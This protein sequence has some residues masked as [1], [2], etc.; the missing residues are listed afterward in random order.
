MEQLSFVVFQWTPPKSFYHYILLITSL[1]IH[2]CVCTVLFLKCIP[3][4]ESDSS[5]RS[6][7]STWSIHVHS[8]IWVTIIPFDSCHYLQ[9]VYIEPFVLFCRPPPFPW[10]FLN[11]FMTSSLTFSFD[12][13]FSTSFSFF[14]YFFLSPSILPAL[15]SLPL[16]LIFLH[17]FPFYILVEFPFLFPLVL[18]KPLSL[19]A[20][21]FP[22]NPA[23]W[24][25]LSKIST[26]VFASFSV[27]PKLILAALSTS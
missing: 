23:F 21:S 6:A 4:E 26:S 13:P 14:C 17:F 24:L 18:L 19:L 9:M 1:V 11:S 22:P 15:V 20:F 12:F 3:Q 27:S 2:Y 16:V 25:T 8:L 7:H 10:L 5:S